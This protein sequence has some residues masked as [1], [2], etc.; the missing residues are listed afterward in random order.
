MEALRS[1]K[2]SLLFLGSGLFNVTDDS[3]AYCY[4]ARSLASPP[5]LA[6]FF[7]SLSHKLNLIGLRED[8]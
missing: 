6:S 5:A 4:C 7:L 1:L 3:N 8:T 2:K